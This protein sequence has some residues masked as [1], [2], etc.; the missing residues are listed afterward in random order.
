MIGTSD[1]R[2]GDPNGMVITDET[3][4]EAS[5]DAEPRNES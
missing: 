4:D 1:G 3:A 2:D 5:D